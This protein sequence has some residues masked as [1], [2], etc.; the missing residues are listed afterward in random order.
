MHQSGSPIFIANERRIM[1]GNLYLTGFMGSG[2]SVVGKKLARIMGRRFVDNDELVVEELGMPIAQA[3]EEQG[4]EAFRQAETKTLKR[5]ARRRNSV[6]ATGGGLPVNPRNREI[7]KRNGIIIH[8]GAG[9]ETCTSRLGPEEVAIRPLWQDPKALK[10]LYESR[11]EAYRDCT[12]WVDTDGLTVDEVCHKIGEGLF[13][14]RSSNVNLGGELSP[15]IEAWQGQE[16]L[17]PYTQGRKVV[18]LTDRNVAKLHL[19]RY[20]EALGNPLTVIMS[21][22]DRSKTLRRAAPIYEAMY[23]GRLD[24]GD[25][26]VALGGGM[27]TDLGAFVAATYMRGIKF[28]LACTSLVG[29]VDAAVGGKA[30]VNLVNI[31]NLVGLFT[32][33]EAVILDL[34]SLGTL[35]R[36]QIAEGLSEAY[37]TGLIL[38]P[39]LA[40]LIS[41]NL[42]RLLRGDLL[43]LAQVARLSAQAKA[44]VVSQD[45]REG[46]VRRILNLGHT[47]GH[48]LESYNNLKVSHGQAVAAGLMVSAAISQERGLIDNDFYGQIMQ[49]SKRLLPKTTSWPPIDQAWNLMMGDK[50]NLSGKLIYV[51]LAGPGEHRIVDDVSKEE[52]ERAVARARQDI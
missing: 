16:L 31:K 13:P 4:E 44:G 15:L 41:Q 18:L 5:V 22:G 27:V 1:K 14:L 34:Y 37:K 35:P 3:F 49:T 32:V 11:Q 10:D 52:V 46:G 8:L 23:A 36:K 30:A 45:F 39:E 33:P 2:K 25:I 20:Q 40:E 51:L 17:A 9:L 29:A 19:A 12:L 7:M 28:I 38:N 21:P 47:Y 48:A 24:R 26:L 43:L 6:V 50:K 42:G